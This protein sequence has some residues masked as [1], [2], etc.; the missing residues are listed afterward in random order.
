MSGRTGA[1][2]PKEITHAFVLKGFDLV[3]SML[4]GEK[5]YPNGDYDKEPIGI[6]SKDIENRHTRLAP[7]WYGVILGKGTK[8]VTRERYEECKAKLPKMNY[9][10]WNSDAAKR[11]KGHLVGVVKIA[12]SLPYDCCNESEWAIGPICN[13]ISHAGWI[14]QPVPCTGNLGAC[15]ITDKEDRERFQLYADCALRDGN[16][17]RTF[18]E[19]RHPYRPPPIC[20][21]VKR[22]PAKRC[23]G[24]RSPDECSKLRE[25][26]LG[27]QEN[28][29]KKM[30][31]Q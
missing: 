8:N 19:D 21:H 4:E 11:R 6:K 28:L 7:G 1:N 17:F 9:P 26:L 5:L 18:A 27:A 29:K 23:I 24:M 16:I 31:A 15:P 22:K 2:S 3:W 13:I 20:P 14:D 30:K 10:P 12:H 25:L